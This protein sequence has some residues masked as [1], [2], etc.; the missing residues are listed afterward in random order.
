MPPLLERFPNP[1]V[2]LLLFAP[3]LDNTADIS[4]KYPSWSENKHCP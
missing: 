4:S 3:V 2:R 1:F